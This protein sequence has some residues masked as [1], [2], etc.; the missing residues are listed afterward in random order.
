MPVG[1]MHQPTGTTLYVAVYWVTYATAV[2]FV[3]AGLIFAPYYLGPYV[4]RVLRC[5]L[6][7]RFRRFI[8]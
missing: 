5:L 1:L 6:A 7:L 3:T 2:S 8:A 4:K